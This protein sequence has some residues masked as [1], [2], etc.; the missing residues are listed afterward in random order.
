MSSEQRTVDIEIANRKGLGSHEETVEFVDMD[1][2]RQRVDALVEEVPFGKVIVVLT[3]S[4]E[5][6]EDERAE[7]DAI[8]RG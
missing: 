5:L 4:W 1:A 6:T 7:L 3:P 8:E 2:L